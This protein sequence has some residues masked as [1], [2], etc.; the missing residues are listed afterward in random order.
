MNERRNGGR[1]ILVVG[2]TGNQGGAVARHLLEGGFRVRAL[3][4]DPQK[5]EARALVERGAEAARGDL[6][7]RASLGR[8]LEGAYGAFSVQNFFEHG[9]EGEVRQGV[10]LA[11]AAK[12]AGV[13][14]FVYSSVGSAHRDTGIPHFDSKFQVEEHVRKIGL[15]HTVLRPVFFMDN[16]EYFGRERI[17]AGALYQPLDPDKPL[18]QISADDIGA[19]AALAFANPERWIGRAVDLAG[20]ELTMPEAAEVFSRVIGREVRYVRVPMEQIRET[21]GEEGARMFEWFNDVG[22]EADIEALRK[23][24]PNLTTL[25]RYLR[26]HGWENAGAAA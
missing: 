20:D 16:W 5:P 1:P 26:E 12:A 9:P 6:D 3:V 24:Y 22:Y 8:A 7:D 4:R 23:E 15:P 18:Q 14:H 25:E 2:A 19:F 17:L 13:E 11:D 10:A 21:M